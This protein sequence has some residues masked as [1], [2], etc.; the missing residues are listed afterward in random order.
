M[1]ALFASFLGLLLVVAAQAQVKPQWTAMPSLPDQEGFAGM[2]GGVS[3]GQLFCMGGANFPGKRPW[4]GGI[5]QWYHSIYRLQD[6]QWLVLKDTLY[7]SLAYGVTVSYSNNIIIAGGSTATAHSKRVVSY[8]WINNSF[9]TENYPDLPMPLA[10]MA[11]ALVGDLLIVAGG[12]NVPAGPALKR[13]FGLD[14]SAVAKGWFELPAWPGRERIAPACAAVGNNFYLFSGETV[15]ESATGQKYRLI[16]SD[17]FYFTPV[18][19]KGKWSGLWTALAPMPKGATAAGLPLPVLQNNT[20]LFWG[21]V[22]A[23]TSAYKDPATHP[24]IKRDV[25]LYHSLNDTWQYAGSQDSIAARVTLP[26]VYWKGGWV[27]LSGEVRP[28][29][30]TNT[31]YSV[32]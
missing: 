24:G 19:N 30:R 13:C 28:G 3:N 17:A 1:R 4:E 25:L 11:G 23:V 22:D 27:F 16:L 26:V 5:K 31:V 29:I 21:G 8:T 20:I 6:N 14:L 12:N 9:K 2:Y 15:G 7:A 10:N 32:K 18:K